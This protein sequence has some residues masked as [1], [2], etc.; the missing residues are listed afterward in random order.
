MFCTDEMLK[1]LEC[2]QSKYG[3]TNVPLNWTRDIVMADWCC[4][5]RQRYREMQS[6]FC[7]LSSK[8]GMSLIF[9]DAQLKIFEELN[10][11]NFSW[12]YD[13]WHWNYWYTKLAAPGIDDSEALSIKV[14]LRDQRRRYKLG[15]LSSER[16]KKLKQVGVSFI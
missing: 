13:V 14:W 7:S 4:L 11:M 2:F 12:D 9:S 3:H 5:Q 1:R 6:G 10:A 16:A 8:E 15:I